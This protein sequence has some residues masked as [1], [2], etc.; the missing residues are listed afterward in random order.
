VISF[1][2]RLF[3]TFPLA[4]LRYWQRK[5]IKRLF[6]AN[7]IFADFVVLMPFVESLSWFIQKQL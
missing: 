2:A 7:V 4:P 3:C 6:R 5:Q 1:Q